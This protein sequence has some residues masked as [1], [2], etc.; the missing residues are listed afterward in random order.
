MNMPREAINNLHALE[1]EGQVSGPEGDQRMAH[2]ALMQAI[3]GVIVSLERVADR[4]DRH[5]EKLGEAV[6]AVHAIDK[7]LAVVESNSV[8]VRLE[9]IETLLTTRIE[10]T[11]SRIDDLEEEHHKR[12]NELE[13]DK[14][15]RAGE[16]STLEKLFASPTLAWAIA[17][18]L[19]VAYAIS[20]HGDT[21]VKVVTGGK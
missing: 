4:Q 8:S 20:Q 17:A 12:I 13:S 5:D 3:N 1:K 14:D 9:K 18:L 21:A 6:E 2:L 15:K 7:R 11:E 16:R 10:K 19:G